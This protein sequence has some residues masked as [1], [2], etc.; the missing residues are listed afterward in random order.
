LSENAAY[1]VDDVEDDEED[2]G[3]LFLPCVSGK[4]ADRDI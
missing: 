1:E 3:V 2:S 4:Q